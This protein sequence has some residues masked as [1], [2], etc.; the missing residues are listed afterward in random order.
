MERFPWIPLWSWGPVAVLTASLALSG[1]GSGG[2]VEPAATSTP[3]PQVSGPTSLAATL[4]PTASQPTLTS[5]PSPSIA[6]TQD[7]PG[8]T[9]T[10]TPIIRAPP[11]RDL[12]RI[13]RTPFVPLDS[14][15]LL[16]VE[17]AE[18][19]SDDDLV[20]GLEWQGQA[21]AYPVSMLT[22]HHVVNDTV[23]GRPVLITY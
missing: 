18:Y 13:R 3:V 4:S 20:L 23:A 2:V 21:R 5:I 22:Y 12:S 17:E 14:P 7:P 10:A 6:A 19:L 11:D 9:L 15:E 1:C 16:R 8:S